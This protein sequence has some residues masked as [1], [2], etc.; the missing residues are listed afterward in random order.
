VRWVE[1]HIVPGLFQTAAYTRGLLSVLERL[2]ELKVFDPDDQVEIRQRRQERLL[3]GEVEVD[4]IVTEEA[5]RRRAGNPA[6]MVEQIDRL[7]HDCARDSVQLWILPTE[8]SLAAA[9]A[10]PFIILTI[11]TR[12]PHDWLF[13]EQH[14]LSLR[15]DPELLRGYDALFEDLKSAALSPEESGVALLGVRDDWSR[16]VQ[17]AEAPLINS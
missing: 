4:V 5:L 9:G 2:P 15:D 11:G 6:V 10:G 12:Q 14:E 16:E 8:A 3:S 7:I 17:V 1:T 13:R